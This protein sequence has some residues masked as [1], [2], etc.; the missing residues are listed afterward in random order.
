[1]LDE[2][3]HHFQLHF[4][5]ACRWVNVSKDRSPARVENGKRRGNK[6][7]WCCDNVVAF[8]YSRRKQGKV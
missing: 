7:L 2:V 3:P 8:L 6:G 4:L 1:M 5:H